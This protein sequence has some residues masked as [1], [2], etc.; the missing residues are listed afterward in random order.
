MA[1]HQLKE[2]GLKS[3]TVSLDGAC[4]ETHDRMRQYPGLFNL[5]VNAIR[6]L[7]SYHHRVGISFTPTLL[8]YHETFEV[9]EL[10]YSLGTDSICVSQYIPTGRGGRDLMLSPTVLGDPHG[11]FCSCAPTMPGE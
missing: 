2:A 10:A 5:A 11:K 6:A 8:N 3:V 4:S 1:W 9:A 7:V